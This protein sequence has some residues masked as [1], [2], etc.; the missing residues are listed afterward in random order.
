MNKE[1]SQELMNSYI[2]S[3][4]GLAMKT[5]GPVPTDSLCNLCRLP[6]ETR[7]AISEQMK[8]DLEKNKDWDKK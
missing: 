5:N 8:Q 6:E 4:C 1:R 2:C 3:K 7:Q